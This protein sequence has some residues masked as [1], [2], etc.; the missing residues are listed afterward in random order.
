MVYFSVKCTLLL[1]SFH[2]AVQSSAV[3]C[4]A[5]QSSAVQCTAQTPDNVDQAL[6]TICNVLSLHVEGLGQA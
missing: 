3:Q 6:E 4:S 2:L 5:V 1:Y